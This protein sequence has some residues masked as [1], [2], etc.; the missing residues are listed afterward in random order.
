MSKTNALRSAGT[1]HLSVIHKASLTTNTALNYPDDAV[2]QTDLDFN[3]TG[4][5]SAAEALHGQPGAMGKNIFHLVDIDFV[6]ESIDELKRHLSQKNFWSGEV[7]FKRFDGQQIYFRTTATYIIG[8]NDKPVAI[9][10]VSHN[11]NDVKN[12]QLQID[13]AKKKYEILM[14]TLPQGVMMITADG[15]IE[16]C[17]KRGAQIFGFTEN[18]MIGKVLVSPSWKAVKAD[19]SVFP[20]TEFPAMVS[21][22]TGFPQRNVIMG[23][24]NPDDTLVWVSI[25]S[26]A[27]IQPGKFEPYA[28]VVSYSDITDS[29]KTEE[30]LKKSNERFYH[31]SKV[32][33]DAIWDIDL[34]SKMI[35]RSGAFRRLSGYA[36]EQ[37]DSNLDWWFQKVHPDD[38]E[39]VKYKLNSYVEKGLERWDDE[40]RFECADGSF[41]FFYD[42]GV[43]LYK[44]GKAVRIIGAIKDLTEQKKL[45]KQ[46]IEEQ[47]QR[48]KD[49]TQAAIDAQE[50]E[51][52]NISRELHDNVNQILMSA[53]L[54]MDTA[55]RI[56]EQTNELLDKAIEYQLLALQEIRKLSKSL[57]TSNVKTVGLEESVGD[58]VGNMKMLQQLDVEF[59]FN[60]K[61]EEKLLDDQKLMLFRII[62]EQT[63]NIIK[64][65]DAKSVQ[66][67]INKANNIIHLVISDD[68]VGFDTS[69]KSTKGI[70]FLN[71]ISR[72]DVY[73]GKVNIV[74]SPGNGCTLE[75]CFPID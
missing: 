20:L 61:V 1:E 69:D 49:I 66:I 73:N 29:K 12:Q 30:E 72:A 53:K 51:K 8:E 42:S 15:K 44:A 7:M 17:N 75:I 3:I 39:R 48:H 58:I 54:F 59:I 67:M 40:Y 28:V 25:N 18:E 64:Y 63:N 57:S 19:G 24:Q 5:N 62:Q 4:W 33:T 27:L 10:I 46:L 35:Y 55:K 14:N 68:G 2:L 74:S 65:A 32:S 56:P 50:K 22:Q 60:E 45:E 16:A 70:G 34:T 26:E 36:Q 13:A 31:V 9:M 37:I 41:K 52:T 11:I 21:L 23:I 71:I 43:I 6:N 38:Q 47:I